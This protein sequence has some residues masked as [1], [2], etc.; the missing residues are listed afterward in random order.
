MHLCL[1]L[2][3]EF[4]FDTSS[5]VGCFGKCSNSV[6][7]DLVRWSLNWCVWGPFGRGS[8][9]SSSFQHWLLRHIRVLLDH[10]P[11]SCTSNVAALNWGGRWTTLKAC[12]ET[13]KKF[14][15]LLTGRRTFCNWLPRPLWEEELCLIELHLIWLQ[16][17]CYGWLL[18][19][20]ESQ[21]EQVWS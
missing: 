19:Y 15:E 8:E 9:G 10:C 11:L 20:K 12:I 3:C 1:W 14:S 17:W 7:G 2:G 16:Y 13:M 4:Q 18:P 21:A 5:F 6:Q